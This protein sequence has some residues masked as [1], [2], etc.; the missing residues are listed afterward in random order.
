MLPERYS[1]LLTAFVDG[2]LSQRQRKAVLRLLRRSAEARALLRQLQ[3]DAAALRNLPRLHL[4]PEFADRLMLT[5]RTG[6][7]RPAQHPPAAPSPRPLPAWV[8]VGMAASVLLLVGF[9]SYLYFRATLDDDSGAGA[10]ALRTPAP[11]APTEGPKPEP[12]PADGAP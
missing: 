4:G 7:L 6:R 2:E 12:A 3:A 10:L 1:Q 8:G 11:E 9:G 5:V